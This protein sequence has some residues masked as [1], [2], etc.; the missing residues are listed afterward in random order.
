M[1]FQIKRKFNSQPNTKTFFFILFYRCK[2]NKFPEQF[3][4]FSQKNFQKIKSNKI[5]I[6]FQNILQKHFQIISQKIF[7]NKL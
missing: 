1:Y 6:I 5:Q 3:Q 7:P 4:I 2:V